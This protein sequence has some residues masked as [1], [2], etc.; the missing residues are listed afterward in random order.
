MNIKYVCFLSFFLLLNPAQAHHSWTASYTDEYISV[1]GTVDRYLFKNP[2][3]VVYLNVTN[4]S[5]ET[6]RW[7]SEGAAATG[8][9]LAAWDEDTLTEGE[10]IRITGRAG[11]NGRPMVSLG[12]VARVDRQTGAAVNIN[13]ERAVVYANDPDHPCLLYTSPSPRDS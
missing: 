8:L 4:D 7:M 9:R 2:H 3:V 13:L 10:Y 11:R 12:E 5:G 1:E 6:T